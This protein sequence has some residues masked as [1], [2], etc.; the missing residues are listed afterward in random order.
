FIFL[1]WDIAVS[2]NK[3]FTLCLMGKRKFEEKRV[4]CSKSLRKSLWSR[5][6]RRCCLLSSNQLIL[7]LPLHISRLIYQNLKGLFLQ[8]SF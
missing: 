4:H 6:A 8:K 2:G 3:S 1:L 7:E 5:P